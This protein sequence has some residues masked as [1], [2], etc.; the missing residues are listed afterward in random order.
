MRKLIII[1]V[2][3]LLVAGGGYASYYFLFRTDDQPR[4]AAAEAEADRLNAEFVPF[5][6][7][8]LPVI[9]HGNIYRYI[10]LTITLEVAGVEES[11]LVKQRTSK[12]NAVFLRE[13]LRSAR[14][15]DNTNHE[16]TLPE[17]KAMLRDAANAVLGDGVVRAVLIQNL[18]EWTAS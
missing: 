10:G 4:D 3:L 11:D 2:P 7:V 14:L 6:T 18:N 5:G 15:W 16:P 12:L 9:R 13:G 1:L 8:N 17:I